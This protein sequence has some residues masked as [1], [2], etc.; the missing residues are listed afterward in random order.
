V[1]S[2]EASVDSE[3]A[4][5]HRVLARYAPKTFA[6]GK[7]TESSIKRRKTAG[8]ETCLRL[9]SMKMSSKQKERSEKKGN[10]FNVYVNVHDIVPH[11]FW[12]ARIEMIHPEAALKRFSRLARCVR[13]RFFPF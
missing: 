4:G 8:R 1:L 7:T 9:R 5:L 12:T 11:A 6:P 3:N 13:T 2:S 10:E